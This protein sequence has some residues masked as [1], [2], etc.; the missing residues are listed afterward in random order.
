[1]GILDFGFWILD[2]GRE[3]TTEARKSG[4][5]EGDNREG[6]KRA[7]AR[8]VTQAVVEVLSSILS[9][10][11]GGGRRS[12]KLLLS[13]FCLLLALP[14]SAIEHF[15]PPDFTNGYTLPTTTTPP[16]RADLFAYID[17]GVLFA[18]LLLASYLVLW[19]RSRRGIA[20][21]AIFS[22]AYFGFYRHGC[23][24]PIGSIQNVSLSLADSSYAL[25]VV[26]GAFFLLPL[27]FAL[28]AGRVF[29]AAVCPLG[30][31]QDIVLL[32]PL[33]AP[34]WLAH[35]LGLIPWVYL[36][37]AV[38]YAATGTTFLICHYDPFVAF[39]RLGGQMNLLIYGAVMLLLAVFVGRVYCRFLCPYGA[40][41]R[42]I[43]P[44]AKWRVTITPDDCVRCRLCEDACPFDQITYPTPRD[45]SINREEGKGHLAMLLVLLPVL[46]AIGAGLGYLGS[47]TLAT[48]DPKVRIARMVWVEDHKTAE[49]KAAE[50]AAGVKPL[51]EIEAVRKH[52]TPKEEVYL[53][54][55]A[56]TRKFGI[57]GPI[58][59]AWIGLV[60][61]LKLIGLSIF[62]KRTDYEPDSAGCVACGRCYGSCRR[63][64]KT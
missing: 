62:R 41:L 51:L 50:Q 55:L 37:A 44:L 46:I 58:F 42:L 18:A 10:V 36:G 40:L 19:K 31:A 27:V 35:C 34:G 32:R 4:N 7:K 22:L 26:V 21:L 6:A 23:V 45:V 11:Q 59:G 16:P 17:V 2:S 49:Q 56:V 9:C 54:A 8:K 63:G 29:C 28:F 48:L 38:L 53:D 33:K 12:V 3:S 13:A 15:P 60:I 25:P 52:D 14:A 61:G 57:G 47:G 1:M 20:A 43:S 24:C 30:A 39:F 64:G 5:T